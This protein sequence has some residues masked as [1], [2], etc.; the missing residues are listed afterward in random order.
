[1]VGGSNEITARIPDELCEAGRYGQKNGKGYYLY[2]EGSRRPLPDPEADE[3]IQRVAKEAGYVSKTFS[4]E[5]IRKRCIYALINVGA[6]LLEEGH[7]LRAGDIDTVYVNG[8]GFPAFVG[9][10]MWYADQEGLSSVL[11]DIE[12]FYA[13]TGDESWKPAELLRQLAAEG[14][15]FASLDA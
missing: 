11:A 15:N 1:M 13:E 9:G 6:K 8:Y 14:K 10:P 2:E 3:I 12:R 4:D 7:A 5:E